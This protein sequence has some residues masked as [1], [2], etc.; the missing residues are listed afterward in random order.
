MNRVLSFV[1]LA[2]VCMSANAAT[3]HGA[4]EDQFQIVPVR[5]LQQFSN[6]AYAQSSS[7]NTFPFNRYSPALGVYSPAWINNQQTNYWYGQGVTGTA[8]NG[9]G[10]SGLT[11]NDCAPHGMSTIPLYAAFAGTNALRT[12]CPLR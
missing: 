2:V 10:L 11:D 7:W 12:N 4:A 5:P 9:T 1:V 8:P 3:Q 6:N